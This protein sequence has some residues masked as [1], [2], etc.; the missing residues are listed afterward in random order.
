MILLALLVFVSFS[1]AFYE[2]FFLAGKRYAVDPYLLASIAKV[3]SGF[4]PKAINRNKN[5]S[6]D[7]GIMQINSYWIMRYKI[8]F[9]WLKEPCYNI[10]F[11]AMVL[12]NCIDIHRGNLQLAIDCYNK[13]ARASGNSLYVLRVYNSYKKIINMVR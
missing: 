7:Y 13:G 1:Y 8:P 5:G 12:R 11:G 6:I 2:C 9:E 3:E 10:H 4:N